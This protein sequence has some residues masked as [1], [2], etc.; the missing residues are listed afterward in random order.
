M[1]IAV[2]AFSQ[3]GV[4]TA[5]RLLIALGGEENKCMAFAA[6]K[7]AGDV[8]LP[9]VPPL[10]GFTAPAFDWADALIFVSSCGTAV[11]AIGRHVRDKDADPAVVVVDENG[12]FAVSLLT[13]RANSLARRV[14]SMLRA[15]PVVTAALE[16]SGRFSLTAWAEQEGLFVAGKE[17]ME[18]IESALAEGP[19]PLFSDF[20]IA[21]ALPPNLTE[22]SGGPVGISISVQEKRP[23][24]TTLL[25]VPKVLRLGLSSHGNA[26]TGL[27][28]NVVDQ[29]LE[30]CSIHSAAVRTA[31][32]IDQEW[33][34]R[35]MRAF[36]RQ[37][38]WPVEYYAAEELAALNGE[39]TPSE[40]GYGVDNVCERAAVM[41]GARLIVREAEADGVAVALAIEPWEVKF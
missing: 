29:V 3:Q 11:R 24:E 33:N 1:K 30:V 12:R 36:C 35:G 21:T 6:K 40:D 9:I 25:L 5:R 37:R 13:E 10:D 27:V 17:E 8:F 16:G 39:F 19:V 7:W 2:F 15:M 41:G 32:S 4:E 20:P 34:E 38:G 18:I 22:G 31:A 14:A 23:F 28:A 26:G